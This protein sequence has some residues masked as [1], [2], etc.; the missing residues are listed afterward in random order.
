MAGADALSAAELDK[1][2][3]CALNWWLHR[4]GVQGTDEKLE[5]G[6]QAHRHLAKTLEDIRAEEDRA[7]EAEALILYFTIAATLLAV[8]GLSILGTWPASLGQVLAVVALQWLLAAVYYL[9]R[10]E[11]VAPP[12]EKLTAERITVAFAIV[13][14]VSAVLAVSSALVKDPTLGVILEVSALLWLVGACY[15]LYRSLRSLERAQALRRKDGVGEGRVEYQDGGEAPAPLLT[16]QRYGL[17]GRPDYILVREGHRIP[18]EVKTGRVP[19]GPLFSHILQVAAYCVLLEERY[20]EAPPYGILKYGH[21]EHE[22]E[23]TP[24]LKG[25]LLSK[26]DEMRGLLAKGVVHRNHNREGK[27]LHCSRRAACPE[28]LA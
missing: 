23:Y 17:K 15:F 16:S 5:A 9:Y 6:R 22:I 10:A 24:E 11:V 3:Y 12:E 2:G 18:V 8:L 28:R 13:A 25:L 4:Q 21:I 19:R 20:G 1:F 26:L 7:R 14:T 27:C